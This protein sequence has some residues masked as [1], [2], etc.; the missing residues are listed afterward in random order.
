MPVKRNAKIRIAFFLCAVLHSEFYGT[1]CTPPFSK[2]GFYITELNVCLKGAESHRDFAAHL[3]IMLRVC[4]A[5]CCGYAPHYAAGVS[6]IMLRV[7]PALCCGY[8]PHYGAG[9]PRIM[10][11]VCPALCC[12]YAPHYAAGMSR[13]MV[14]RTSCIIGARIVHPC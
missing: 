12:G 14:Q 4:P 6:R 7:C 10:L 2:A 8:V 1:C 3:F 9:V 11:R 13:I 5:L